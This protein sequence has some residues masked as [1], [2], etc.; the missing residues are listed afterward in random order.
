MQERFSHRSR[1]SVIRPPG[2]LLAYERRFEATHGPVQIT[3]RTPTLT[4]RHLP[5]SRD[6]SL[7]GLGSVVHP[8]KGIVFGRKL[9]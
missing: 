4:R 8:S 3:R 9:K 7:S 5:K 2:M 6:L 1:D